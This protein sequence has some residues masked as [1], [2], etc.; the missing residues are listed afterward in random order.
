MRDEHHRPA[1]IFAAAI[2]SAY[3]IAAAAAGVGLRPD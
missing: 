1:T 2:S 3:R